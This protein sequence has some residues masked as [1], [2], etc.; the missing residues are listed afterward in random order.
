MREEMAAA[1]VRFAEDV[2]GLDIMDET[3]PRVGRF[4][5]HLIED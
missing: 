2:A 3:P 4:E 1:G 5:R